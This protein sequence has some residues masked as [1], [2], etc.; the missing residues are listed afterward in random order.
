M[1]Q[2]R[3]PAGALRPAAVYH[4]L[5]LAG[6][7]CPQDAKN[8]EKQHCQVLLEIGV[9]QEVEDHPNAVQLFEVYDEA[10]QYYLVMEAS[11]QSKTNTQTHTHTRP[12]TQERSMLHAV[13][14]S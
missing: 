6:P 11:E 9:M 3:P 1:R 4:T 2:G 5:D 13:T 14:L 7:L 12:G 10:K 8:P